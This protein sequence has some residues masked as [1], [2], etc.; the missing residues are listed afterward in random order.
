M[1]RTMVPWHTVRRAAQERGGAGLVARESLCAAR[2]SCRVPARRILSFS[3][4]PGRCRGKGLPG[5][6]P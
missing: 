2:L 6:W 4:E 3:R 1:N 5:E